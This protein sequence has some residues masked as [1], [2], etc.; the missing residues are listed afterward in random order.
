MKLLNQLPYPFN[1]LLEEL[2]ESILISFTKDFEIIDKNKYF[3]D[4]F[5][6]AK[7]DNL[8]DY[9]PPKNLQEIKL[10]TEGYNKQI[11]KFH[12]T[13]KVGYNTLA[14]IFKLDDSYLL[15]GREV[16]VEEDDIFNKISLLNNNLANKNH[17][18]AKK[19]RQLKQAQE[20]IE[21]FNQ[22]LQAQNS[23]LEQLY[24]Q[25]DNEVEKA[26]QLHQ[27]FLPSNLPQIEGLTAQAYFQPSN[28]LGG[29]FYDVIELKGQL[30]FYL[31]D[32]S[33]HGLDGSILNIFLRETINNYLLYHYNDI[34]SLQPIRLMEFIVDKYLEEDFPN[35][36][37]ICL[38]MGVFDK[39][40]QECTFANAGFQFLPVKITEAGETS[41][42][43]CSGTPISSVIEKE[44][45]LELAD[46]DCQ[47]KKVLLEQ[48]Q[49]FFL[50]TDGLLEE[51]VNNKRYGMARLKKILSNNAAFPA[52]LILKKIKDD[53]EEFSGSLNGQD[54]LTLLVLKNNVKL[55][56]S[57]KQEIKSEIEEIY[58]LMKEIKS[59]ITPYFKAKE[60]ICFAL[61]EM[62]INAIEHGNQLDSNKV[63]K[64]N[65]KLTKNYCLAE[66]KDQG[67]GFD[68]REIIRK[69][70]DIENN[71]A[72][73]R[74]RGIKLAKIAF[75]EVWYNEKGNQAYLL[76]II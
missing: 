74:G 17:K 73:E 21:D 70:L 64:I 23:E 28:R 71:L 11:V 55:L 16:L 13:A 31:S 68:W 6:K 19:N 32:V 53:F 30:L 18:L 4:L 5:S 76:K 26:H 36:Y 59:F 7:G 56:N 1:C 72:Q 34:R 42:I 66:I 69:K 27:Q 65:L 61:Q 50:T 60:N 43:F 15:F 9:I 47:N 48:G 75:D 37:F 54:D 2:D 38:L 40:S 44:L 22:E 14:H 45:F 62:M 33:G 41:D 8:E 35:D 67:A 39:Q 25:L 12:A 29:D 10:P 46:C 58:R 49:S 51:L 3:A 24:N 20:K 57:F 52:S 63:V